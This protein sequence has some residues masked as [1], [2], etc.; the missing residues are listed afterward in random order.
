MKIKLKDLIKNPK[1]FIKKFS[2]NADI[3][4]GSQKDIPIQAYQ[5][6][7]SFTYKFDCGHC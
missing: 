2:K 7:K 4:L 1:S 5:L 6:F 3:D